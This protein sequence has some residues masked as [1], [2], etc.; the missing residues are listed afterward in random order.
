M[1]K[2]FAIIMCAVLLSCAVLP[3]TVS[4]AGMVLFEDKFNENN[5]ENWMIPPSLFECVDGHL[6][7]NAS[8]V[9]HQSNFEDG[10]TKMWGTGVSFAIDGFA[11]DD[12]R[13][14]GENKLALWWADYFKLD[15]SD[16]VEN[17]RI[18]YMFGYDYVHSKFFFSASYEGE[19][20]EIY[21]PEEGKSRYFEIDA[22]VYKMDPSKPDVIRMGMKIDKGVIYCYDG[23]NLVFTYEADRGEECGTGARSPVLIWNVNCYCGFDNFIV[24]TADYNLFN[25]SAA[26][27]TA[28]PADDTTTAEET[29]KVETKT[30]VV[31]DENGEAHTEIVTEIVT[32]APKQETNTQ[33]SDVNNGGAQTGD[34]LTVVIAVMTVAFGAAI[35]VKKVNER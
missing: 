4:A 1:K 3:F 28:G 10:G 27:S 24:T 35:I 20:S 14:T 19:S 12:E 29:T 25:E 31:T 2:L 26:E 32:N 8:C 18:C 13:G 5:P 21:K 30:V 6:E 9:V 23:N 33:K 22:P 15:H 34:M 17:G 11:Y 16:D 7:G